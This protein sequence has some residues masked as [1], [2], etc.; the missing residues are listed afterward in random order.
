[1]EVPTQAGRSVA[2]HPGKAS[3]PLSEVACAIKRP[4]Y[5]DSRSRKLILRSMA[6]DIESGN[7]RGT[8]TR[9]RLPSMSLA[10]L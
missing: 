4:V 10:G 5:Y 6:E 9:E 2:K 3:V 1:M 8:R 7:L